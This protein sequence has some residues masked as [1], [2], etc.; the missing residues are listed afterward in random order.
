MA[1][2]SRVPTRGA[3]RMSCIFSGLIRLRRAGAAGTKDLR[4]QKTGND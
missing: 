2:A 1:V 3:Y 4:D